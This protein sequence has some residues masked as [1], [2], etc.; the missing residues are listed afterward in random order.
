MRLGVG[1][2]LW[3]MQSVLRASV[4][5]AV[6][7]AHGCTADAVVYRAALAPRDAGL[8]AADSAASDA[9]MA[10]FGCRAQGGGGNA[11]LTEILARLNGDLVPGEKPRCRTD[12]D[13]SQTFIT[14]ACDEASGSCVPCAGPLQQ[15][16]FGVGL[17][18]CLTGAA[19]RCCRDPEAAADCIVKACAISCGGS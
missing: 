4:C 7:A 5:C 13:C 17:G 6:F 14:P 18:A 15:V 12:A 10:V 16:A 9:G 3:R 1:L 11:I 19:A 8:P 2:L